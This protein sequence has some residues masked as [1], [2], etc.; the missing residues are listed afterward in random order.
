MSIITVIM[1]WTSWTAPFRRAA[2]DGGRPRTVGGR[3]GRDRASSRGSPVDGSAGRRC[4]PPDHP[5]L[6]TREGP[7]I[8]S[9][10]AGSVHIAVA[11]S[12]DSGGFSTHGWTKTGSDARPA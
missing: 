6:S 5:E 1:L 3:T 7:V 4:K 11:F 12:T 2:A 8:R 10:A 9:P